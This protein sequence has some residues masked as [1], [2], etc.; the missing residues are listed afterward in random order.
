MFI[1]ELAVPF[2]FFAPRR[3]R[4]IGGILTALL[5]VFIL[6]T[7]NYTFFN[8]LTLALC[9]TLLDDFALEKLAPGRLRK[10]HTFHVSGFTSHRLRLWRRAI[11]VP[12]AVVVISLTT[13]QLLAM[14]DVRSPLFKPVAAMS[15]WLAPLR[16]FNSYGLFAV[17]TN[18]RP[19][20]ILEG[21]NDGISWLPYEFKYKPGDVKRRP[22]IVAPHQPRLDW[23]MWFAALGNWRQNP[24]IINLTTRLLHGS[25]EVLG[26]LQ[27]NP[28]PDKPPRFVRAT[29]HEYRFTDFA[30]RRKTGAWWQ[31]K[32]IGEYLPPISSRG[33]RN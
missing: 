30:E 6:F 19:E 18:K 4:M 11:I 26:L 12:L 29:L 16:S 22:G 28:F 9:L 23:Q 7:G 20:I 3:L 25:P 33:G 24:W 15:Q 10:S 27:K 14:F 21:S 32:P 2:L 13:L 17:M 1:I 8:W 5:Q 31:R